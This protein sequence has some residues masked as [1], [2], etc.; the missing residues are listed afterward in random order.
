MDPRISDR[1]LGDGA[2]FLR[3]FC[4][5]I[6]LEPRTCGLDVGGRGALGSLGFIARLHSASF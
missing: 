3:I 2:Q 6:T 1:A 5:L 4:G